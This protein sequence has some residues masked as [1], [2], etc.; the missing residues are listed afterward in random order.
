MRIP[1]G[2]L[3]ANVSWRYIVIAYL[4]MAIGE[5][6]LAPIGLSMV[7]RLSPPRYT[8]T[9]VGF[10][11]LCVG[12]AFFNGGLLASFMNHIDTLFNFFAIFVAMTLVPAL[13]LW[14]LAKKLTRMSHIEALEDSVNAGI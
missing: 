2:A 8:A 13:I 7:S 6:L 9:L 5:M 14:A 11:Y 1:E 12:I 3:T 4:F 10:W